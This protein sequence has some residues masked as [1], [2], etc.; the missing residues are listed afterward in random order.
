MP[1]RQAGTVDRCLPVN[2]CHRVA[3]LRGAVVCLGVVVGSA[4][5]AA[6]AGAVSF[7]FYP[8]PGTLQANT[9]IATGPDGALWFT[10]GG[11][12]FAS[13]VI[14]RIATDGTITAFPLPSYTAPTGIV[15]GPD[16]ALWFCEYQT[17]KIARMT[18]AG[19]VTNEYPTAGSPA[20]ITVGP[21]G[22]LWFADQSVDMI[23]SIAPGASAVSEHG[24]L[25]AGSNVRDIVSGP[26]GDLWFTELSKNQ[27]GQ[28]TSA[29]VLVNQFPTSVSGG[30]PFGIAA[31]PDGRLWFG[32][33]GLGVGRVSAMT[34]AG[35]VS[36]YGT[37][38]PGVSTLGI[39]A[40]PDGALYYSETFIGGSI[41]RIAH[42]GSGTS[43]RAYPLPDGGQPNDITLGPDGNIWFVDFGKDAIGK[44]I[45]DVPPVVATGA[46]T[47]VGSSIARLTGTV[48]PRGAA[49]SFQF[50]WGTDTGYG[51]TTPLRASGEDDLTHGV[52][53]SLSGLAPATTY[54]FRI[55]ASSANGTIYGSDET[56]TTGAPLTLPPLTLTLVG[57]PSVSGARLAFTVACRGASGQTC[58]GAA[59][60]TATEALSSHGAVIGVTSRRKKQVTV[61]KTGISV[62]AGQTRKLTLTLNATGK[63][64]IS[65]FKRLPALL[66]ITTTNASGLKT[67]V[68]KSK[69]VFTSNK[70]AQRRRR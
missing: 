58:S 6:P 67:T 52:S 35:A 65:R 42:D 8:V 28:M 30:A 24:G 56:F 40:G 9:T 55:L 25:T 37:P 20:G 11:G 68:A 57:K 47:G 49:T 43:I 54:H 27:I 23:G 39:T 36:S 34:V 61:G 1:P 10:D 31:G 18:T 62:P 51:S 16:G 70:H 38:D 7:S 14:R 59:T 26:D 63:K 66:T 15:A 41:V 33:S 19:V 17:H 69:V 64:L 3:T 48:R 32:N 4:I 60:L 2:Y 29:G 22:A 12:D 44:M 5:G 45:P 50:Q 53:A 21:D 13:S 46:A